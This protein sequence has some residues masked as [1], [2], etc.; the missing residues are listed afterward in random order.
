MA[1]EDSVLKLGPGGA[2]GVFQETGALIQCQR[3]PEILVRV[4]D[5][6]KERRAYE[7]ADARLSSLAADER[8][9]A[10]ESMAASLNSAA[11]KH[12]PLCA[13]ARM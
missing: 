1:I 10:K 5:D 6:E 2:H 7:L 12:C 11:D 9:A 4:R 3:H 13:A 8:R